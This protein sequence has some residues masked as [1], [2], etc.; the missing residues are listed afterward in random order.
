MRYSKCVGFILDENEDSFEYSLMK[1]ASMLY[2]F[3][4]RTC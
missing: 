1:M 2:G 3:K 4:V